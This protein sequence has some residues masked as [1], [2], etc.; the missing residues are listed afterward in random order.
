MKRNIGTTGG[1]TEGLDSFVVNNPNPIFRIDDSDI[2]CYANEGCKTLF[3][4]WECGVGTR[5]PGFWDGNIYAARTSGKQLSIEISNE[6]DIFLFD[7]IPVDECNTLN[8]YGR[9]ITARK[10]YEQEIQ[11]VAEFEHVVN[12]ISSRLMNYSLINYHEVI[13]EVLGLSG[14]FFNASICL[15]SQL[16]ESGE[17]LTITHEWNA[18]RTKLHSR[19]QDSPIDT[20]SWLLSKVFQK[21]IVWIEDTAHLPPEAAPERK[22]LEE[23][24]SGSCI[25]MP[26]IFSG[27]ALGF[28]CLLFDNPSNENLELFQPIL[29]I[30]AEI[31]AN[32]MLYYRARADLITSEEKYRSLIETM[33]DAFVI[34]DNLGFLT[35][36][37]DAM[38]ELL[39]YSRGELIGTHVRELVLPEERDVLT[40]EIQKGKEGKPS[41][42]EITLMTKEASPVRV[43]VSANGLFD[44][45]GVYEGR[46][47]VL[48][49]ITSI[50]EMEAVMRQRL[51]LEKMISSMST[52][53][54][55]VFPENVLK[56]VENSL[57]SIAT[58]LQADQAIFMTFSGNRDE[59]SSLGGWARDDNVTLEQELEKISN[60]S[61]SWLAKPLESEEIFHYN[62]LDAFPSDAL[63]FRHYLESCDATGALL[64]P[65]AIQ[66]GI[67]GVLLFTFGVKTLNIYKD[68]L[69][70]LKILGEIFSNAW[71]REIAE[72]KLRVSEARYRIML[73]NASDLVSLLDE[74]M[75]HEFVNENQLNLLGYRKEEMIGKSAIDFVH[76]EDL[77]RGLDT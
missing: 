68:N 21:E 77:R 74:K 13:V 46:F 76:P 57:E 4:N 19:F 71:E 36:C 73:E 52:R 27:N 25:I 66:G 61:F 58:T 1:N 39:G 35:Y 65:V 47:A 15:I 11:R 33:S 14:E 53:F 26:L 40:R 54:I 72:Q 30:L 41:R 59:V 67:T 31:I 63:E 37:N 50:R 18:G 8:F 17:K 42:Y 3:E 16:D 64:I 55:N 38:C 48:T 70:L 29:T 22:F 12:T 32:S 34:Q 28:M 23:N 20:R 2:I 43:I 51:A 45:Q 44:N 7:I 69:F 49:D 6:E 10:K 60:S 9:K 75:N 56:T 62:D 5:I 24:G